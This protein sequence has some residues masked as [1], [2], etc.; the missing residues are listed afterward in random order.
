MSVTKHLKRI[1]Q[2][3]AA[4]STERRTKNILA[5]PSD[6]SDVHYFTTPSQ[7]LFVGKALREH[8]I[9]RGQ[10]DSAGFPFQQA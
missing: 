7:M 8:S 6:N 4:H 1:G 10:T 5:P 3:L 9:S 2:V